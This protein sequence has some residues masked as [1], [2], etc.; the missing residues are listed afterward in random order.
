MWETDRVAGLIHQKSLS[1]LVLTVTPTYSEQMFY[2]QWRLL[3]HGTMWSR[4]ST[5][6]KYI[7]K[8]L[9]PS[10][11]DSKICYITIQQVNNNSRFIWIWYCSINSL[12][13]SSLKVLLWC[14]WW[15]KSIVFNP[16]LSNLLSNVCDYVLSLFS[17]QFTPYAQY[18]LQHHWQTRN[19]KSQNM[20]LIHQIN[21]NT[22][23]IFYLICILF[24]H[25]SVPSK[26]NVNTE[27][28][29]C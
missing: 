11:H 9:L 1:H 23:I 3:F 12:H 6:I 7:N 2:L 19:T 8:S 4:W 10:R 18:V 29:L 28:Y 15:C 26:E 25:I 16:L 22:A 20:T 21:L 13:I 24:W 17:Q 5:L 14:F 27:W